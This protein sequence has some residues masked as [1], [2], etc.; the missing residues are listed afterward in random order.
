[1]SFGP[2]LCG[3]IDCPRCYPGSTDLVECDSCGELF[4]RYTM[5]ETGSGRIVCSK[6]MDEYTENEANEELQSDD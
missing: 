4:R 3:A 1:M 2:C 5:E 6:C